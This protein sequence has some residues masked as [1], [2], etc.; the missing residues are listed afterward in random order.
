[1]AT[2]RCNECGGEYSTITNDGGAY[3]HVCPPRVMARVKRA[4]GSIAIVDPSAIAPGET[5]LE[6]R[7]VTRAKH[8]NENPIGTGQQPGR[9][10]AEGAGATDI[11]R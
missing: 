5:Y 10:I 11:A 7:L 9:P 4:D 8:R 2:R 1:M 6:E 3:F